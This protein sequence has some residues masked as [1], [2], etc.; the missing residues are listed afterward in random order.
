MYPAKGD[1]VRVEL[2]RLGVWI[3][4]SKISPTLAR[5]VERLGYGA[6]WIG[7]SPDGDLRLAEQLLEVTD[8]VAVAT[9]IVN[10]WKDPAR[11]VAASHRRITA[12]FPRRFLLGIGVGHPERTA[13]YRKPY[14][15]LVEY[16]DVLDGEGVPIDER[17]LAG[18]GPKVLRLGADRT[19]G[20]H[21]YLTT[22]EHTRHA[23]ELLGPKAVIAPEQKVVLDSD[24]A[25]ARALARP[26]VERYLPLRNYAANL[27]RLQWCDDDLA[28]GGSNALIDAL[29]A[30]GDPPHAGTRVRE[31]L[32]AG[33]NH[34]AVQLIT[35]SGVDPLP[36]YERFAAA[37]PA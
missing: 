26:V 22:P 7:A 24:A 21:P 16:L 31:H 6:I 19:A 17:V 29:V 9:G 36:Q 25:T 32:D 30:H 11:T 15:A 27:R 2:G 5:S 34:V 12:R 33:A 28:D 4:R 35:A 20:V 23:R 10:V 37:L 13:E 18:L 1:E 14:T 3:N 8:H